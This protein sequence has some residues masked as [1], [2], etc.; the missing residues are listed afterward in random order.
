VFVLGC[1]KLLKIVDL[2]NSLLINRL[3]DE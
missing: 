2:L 3:N 1:V